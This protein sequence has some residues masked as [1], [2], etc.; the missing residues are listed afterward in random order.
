MSSD[1]EVLS[2]RNVLKILSALSVAAARPDLAEARGRQSLQFSCAENNDLYC[3]ATASGIP[4]ARYE[5]A[6]EAIARAPSGSGV[7]ILAESY[8]NQQTKL[9]A[10]AYQRAARKRLRLYVEFP[11]SVPGLNPGDP[12]LV[13]LGKYGNVLER[14]VVRSNAFGP[15]LKQMRIL[16]LHKC[17]Y[18][19]VTV[20][21]ALLVMA[22]VAGFDA[23]IYG[24][25]QEGAHPILF[26]HPG[27]S[28]LIATTKL[29]NFIRGRYDPAE[30]WAHV[31]RWILSWLSAGPSASLEKWSPAVRPAF[32]RDQRLPERSQVDAFRKGVAW[33]S[34]ARLLVAPQ[35][36]HDVDE[37]ARSGV[38]QAGPGPSWPLGDGS[39]GVLEGFSS[40]IE[41]DGNQ[42]I[43]WSLRNDCAGETSMA[44]AFSGTIENKAANRRIAANLNNFIYFNSALASGPRDDPNSPS[45]GLVGWEVP[46]S[47]GLY[48]GD[49]NARS[50]LGTMVASALLNTDRWNERV[51]RCLLANLRTTGVL[52]FSPD[53]LTDRELQ[54]LGWWHFYDGKLV[55]YHPHFQ[56]YPWACFLRAYEKTHYAPFLE[57]TRTGIRMTMAAYPNQWRWTNGFQQE[58]ARMLLP[59]A[60]LIRVEDNVEHR[61]WLRQIASDLL[62]YQDSSGAIRE[63]LGPPGAGISP[64][65]SNDKYGTSESPLIQENGDPVCDLLYTCNFAFLGLHEAAA[66]TGDPLYAAAENNLAEFFCRIQIE[67]EAHPE[68]SGGWFRAF[69]YRRWDYWASNSDTSWGPWSI[70]TGWTQSWICSVLA[71]RHL[72]TSLWEL[73]GRCDFGAHLN[74][75]LPVMFGR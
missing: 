66:A 19:P 22:R 24:L 74:A 62:S 72:K 70:E 30:A 52:G 15:A 75:L 32:G 10:G 43:S 11:S 12:R 73:T 6:K 2:R 1:R 59:L 29:S 20:P 17:H 33:F 16:S 39:D 31:W 36:K 51:L 56:A 46:R 63:E 50:M 8:P 14:V 7:L 21:D 37:Y 9:D 40:V 26:K 44:L 67:S 65:G 35:W 54:K 48:F 71:M 34:N 68:L 57:R 38:P 64:P 49:D 55:N 47:P 18:L 45:F 53:K 5:E 41:W 3:V 69:D 28:I 61:H 27:R 42:P 4:C 23:A 13:A 25:P 60:W 58:R